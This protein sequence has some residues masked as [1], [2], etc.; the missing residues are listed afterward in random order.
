MLVSECQYKHLFSLYLSHPPEVIEQL[1]LI[2]LTASTLLLNINTAQTGN[3]AYT[4]VSITP[5]HTKVMIQSE[6]SEATVQ[7]H[8]NISGIQAVFSYID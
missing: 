2:N 1:T 7:P 8:Q 4:I 5:N 3:R 6:S